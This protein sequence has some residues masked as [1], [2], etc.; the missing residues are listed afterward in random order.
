MAESTLPGRLIAPVV[1]KL[2]FGEAKNDLAY[3]RTRSYQ[4][5][6]DA[7][8]SIRTEYHLWRGD[9]ESRLQRVYT[10]VKR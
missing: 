6:L 3:W 5:R 2:R 8:E 4:E 10:I 9:A 7:L 1:T